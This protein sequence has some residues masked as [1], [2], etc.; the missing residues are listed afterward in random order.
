[1]LKSWIF[2]SV[3]LV[4]AAAVCLFSR[5][6]AAD[7]AFGLVLI[8]PVICAILHRLAR[9]RP[10]LR[11]EMRAGMDKH[12]TGAGT[13]HA[14]SKGLFLTARVSGALV[15][16]NILTG[17]ASVL[18]LTFSL[19]RFGICAIPFTVESAQ[20]GRIRFRMEGMKL[21]DLT[22]LTFVKRTAAV[23]GSAVVYPDLYRSQVAFEPSPGAE[24]SEAE[25]SSVKTGYDISEP[26]WNREYVPGDSIKS[27]HWKLTSKLDKI[28]VREPGLPVE[29]SALLLFETGNP[30]GELPHASLCGAAAEVFLSLSQNLA[31]SGVTHDAGWYDTDEGNFHRYKIAS[32]DDVNGLADKLLSARQAF[33]SR[34]CLAHYVGVYKTAPQSHI[35]IVAAETAYDEASLAPLSRVTRFVVRAAKTA[36]ADCVEMTPETIA[37]DMYEVV[38]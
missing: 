14:E 22:G 20:C 35:V 27:I 24:A 11:V 17:D 23:S 5:A 37:D 12:K 13:L 33:D 21:Y 28:I 25:Y 38:V 31:A 19:S 15:C 26:L 3:A 1:M 4:S 36:E 29:R 7:I 9:L 2:Y 18:P 30:A 16:E 6:A 10:A 32:E 8:F 34:G